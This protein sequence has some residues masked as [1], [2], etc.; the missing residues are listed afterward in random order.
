MIRPQGIVLIRNNMYCHLYAYDTSS[1]IYA[2]IYAYISY[3]QSL[4]SY[5]QLHCSVTA[6]FNDVLVFVSVCCYHVYIILYACGNTAFYIYT[7]HV[8]EYK[9]VVI[10][11]TEIFTAMCKYRSISTTYTDTLSKY[12]GHSPKL[13]TTRMA[14]CTCNQRYMAF[15]HYYYNVHYI[16]LYTCKHK[17]VA[18]NWYC[19]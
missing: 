11:Y 16:L 15:N 2:Y 7:L 18:F 19:K 12:M 6:K 3:I 10:T 17:S 8:C 4:N 9:S 1:Y 13:C 14:C 5:L